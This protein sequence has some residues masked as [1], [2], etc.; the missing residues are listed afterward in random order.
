MRGPNPQQ[1]F[2]NLSLGNLTVPFGGKTEQENF[3]P[4]VD[5]ANSEGTPIHSPVDGV[6]VKEDSGHSQGENNYGNTLEL[7]DAS[8]NTH[9]FHHLQSILA[10]PGQKIS[11]GQSVATLGK[12]GATYSPTGGDPSNLDYRIVNAYSKYINPTPYIKAL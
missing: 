5:I 9:Q 12:S 1:R 7:K 11:K 2:K 8:G 3:H 6:I 10:K 4:G